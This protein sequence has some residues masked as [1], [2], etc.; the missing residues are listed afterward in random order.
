M[1]DLENIRSE[2]DAVIT[3]ALSDKRVVG[4]VVLIARDG[5]LVYQHGGRFARTYDGRARQPAGDSVP[6]GGVAPS[7][8]MPNS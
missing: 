3:R 6:G 7:S 4:T 5:E 8:N 2:I 1:I